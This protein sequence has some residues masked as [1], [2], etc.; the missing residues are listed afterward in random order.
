MSC[1]NIPSL[2][3]LQNTKK[4][5]DDFGRLMG[6]G[7]GTSTNGVTGQVRPTYNKVLS[8][9]NSEFNGQ[10]LNMGF[11]R[12]STF[13][14]GATLTNPRQT[15]LWDI[16]DGG[17]GQEYG[18]SGSFLPSGKVVPP[19]STPASTGGIA[20]GAWISRYDPSL[21]DTLAKS[22][23]YVRMYQDTWDGV[24]DNTAAIT[25]AHQAANLFNAAV[26]YAGIKDFTLQANAQIPI[27]TN[28]DFCGATLHVLNGVVSITDPENTCFLVSDPASPVVTIINAT[29]TGS[30]KAGSVTPLEGIIDHQGGF[31]YVKAPLKIPNRYMDGLDDYSQSFATGWNSKVIHGLSVDLTA[32]NGQL[33]IEHRAPS[34]GIEIT[35]LDI[36]PNNFNRQ[37]IFQIERNNVAIRGLTSKNQTANIQTI[38][39]IIR[40]FKGAHIS[41]ENINCPCQTTGGSE[42]AEGTY[43]LQYRYAANIHVRNMTALGGFTSNTWHSIAGDHVN[44]IYF[45]ECQVK[46]IDGHAGFHNVFINK[47]TLNTTGIAYGWGGGIM[48]VS[49]CAFEFLGDGIFTRGDYG[50]NWFGVIAVNNISFDIGSLNTSR[51]NVINLS[52]GANVATTMPRVITLSNITQVGKFANSNQSTINIS[53]MRNADTVGTVTAPET[54]VISDI[55]STSQAMVCATLDW[56][57]FER[58]ADYFNQRLII[59]DVHG[60]PASGS[61]V[62][63]GNGIVFPAA[64][65]VPTAAASLDIMVSKCDSLL[66]DSSLCPAVRNINI[67][68]S[69]VHGVIT[70]LAASSP[71]VIL[72]GC[73]LDRPATGFTEYVQIGG[74]RS[75]GGRYTTMDGCIIAAAKFDLSRI[76][77]A[78]GCLFE[79]GTDIPTIPAG[80]T[81]S[82]M[83]T[84]IK[85]TTFR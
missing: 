34:R 28:V 49:D 25:S 39:R 56:G 21:R 52:V 68:M 82:D 65:I 61:R 18:W 79:T 17:D 12:V 38:N 36:D 48:R 76:A 15:L 33:T 4:H 77:A 50:G 81:F 2:L 26:S 55:A 27:N 57:S 70:P 19:N 53:L 75:G 30:L 5:I 13:A 85:T 22:I 73:R 83:F 62:I 10:I 8:D 35:G 31:A 60:I 16:A 69:T 84:G 74:D 51:F 9:M 80:W 7:T 66:I 42:T 72:R 41:I 40:I 43:V 44:G 6:T 45:T 63:S 20:I 58:G 67:E 78:T 59:K 3:D 24:V 11:T 37:I 1:E 14:T 64:S 47:C 71:R 23:I 46:R 29:T 54:V 32:Y